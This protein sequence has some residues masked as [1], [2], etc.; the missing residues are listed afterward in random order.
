MGMY[1]K[2]MAGVLCFAYS[3]ASQGG[4][5]SYFC[6]IIVS[7]RYHFA[8]SHRYSQVF[9]VPCDYDVYGD[10][11]GYTLSLAFCGDEMTRK[12]KMHS[13]MCT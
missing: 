13:K 12:W 2:C 8:G 11:W 9:V 3:F 5:R 4:P 7:G 10:A 1:F 6:F